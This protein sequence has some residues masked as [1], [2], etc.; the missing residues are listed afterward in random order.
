M[1]G[2]LCAPRQVARHDEEV[3][4]VE[5]QAGNSSN[6][7]QAARAEPPTQAEHCGNYTYKR[8]FPTLPILS[9]PQNP[10][11]GYKSVNH[12][13]EPTLI[14]TEKGDEGTIIL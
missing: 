5:W 11:T 2:K 13:S 10:P 4:A 6:S 9:P 8:R 1:H 3:T 12:S 14:K 7:S